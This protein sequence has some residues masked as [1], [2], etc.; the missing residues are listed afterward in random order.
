MNI[1]MFDFSVVT[2][3]KLNVFLNTC[4]VNS[5]LL[6]CVLAVWV[7][8]KHRAKAGCRVRI[9]AKRSASHVELGPL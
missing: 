3:V 6:K 1:C 4:S 7:G 8:V 5:V 2:F 9:W